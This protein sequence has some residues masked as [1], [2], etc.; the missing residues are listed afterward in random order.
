[1][2]TL[3]NDAVLT[4]PNDAVLTVPKDAVLTVSKDAVLTVPKDAVLTVSKDALLTVPKDAVLTVSPHQYITAWYCAALLSQFET[5]IATRRQA[6]PAVDAGWT[7][8]V[9]R[10]AGAVHS[11]SIY[12]TPLCYLSFDLPYTALLSLL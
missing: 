5:A 4:V 7:P 1:M 12:P 6:L 11:N 3:P 10:A 2:L 8:D 9:W